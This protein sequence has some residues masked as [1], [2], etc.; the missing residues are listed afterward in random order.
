MKSADIPENEQERIRLLNELG[1]LDT[2]EEQAYDD[3]TYLAAQ[4]CNTPIALVSLVD[5]HRQ[6]FKSHYGL[7]ARET[8][9]D[10][11]FCSHAILGDNIFVVED[12]SKDERFHD[13]P[14]AIDNPNVIFYA[15]A[16]LVMSD[17]LRLG[18]LCVIGHEPR[19]ISNN[20]K[21]ALEA[22]A[23][24]AVNQLE[25]RLKIK[26]LQSLDNAK[27]EFISMVSHELRTPL[28]SICGSLSLLSSNK[29]GQLDD[30]QHNMVEIASRNSS[31]LLCIVNDI[32]DNARLEAGKL[33]IILKPHR[34]IAILEKAIELN[35]PY[36]DK[37]NCDIVL[38]YNKLDS[39]K[40]IECDE[41]RLIQVLTNL[42]SNAAKV[43]RDEDI[44][45]VSL[46][47]DDKN[48]RIE[49]LDHGAGIP[50]DQQK[51]IFQKFKQVETSG[52]MKMPGTGLG[53][54]ISKQI[55]ELHGGT[56]GFE[57]LPNK[58]TKFYFTIGLINN[59]G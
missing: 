23:R 48:A 16:P 53:L 54:R 4:I 56:I 50:D 10:V 44:V 58:Y 59:P 27:D 37:C 15:G 26:E 7:N 21:K 13:N 34:I 45:E 12:S 1:I 11:A 42:I 36:C 39:S 32:L 29:L 41:N 20:Q 30:K 47:I 55:I 35:K 51:F 40:M 22:L 5:S 28:T 3:L 46:V 57:S 18:T 43:S 52:N 14:L 9:R 33:D 8:P 38:K 24:Q 2:L 19:T 31:R 25:L 6:W 49:V 17:K